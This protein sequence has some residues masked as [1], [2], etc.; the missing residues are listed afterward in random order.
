[1][2]GKRFRFLPCQYLESDLLIGITPEDY[3]P[4]M[5]ELSLKELIRIRKELD[6]FICRHPEFT[7][8]SPPKQLIAT[9]SENRM[10]PLF[11]RAML[12]ASNAT[13]TGPMSA[14]AG[15]FASHIARFL[16]SAFAVNELVVENG[17]DLFTSCKYPLVTALHAGKL[18]LSDKLGLEIP[19]EP[20]GVSTSSGTLGHSF[21]AGQADALTVV[22]REAALA[23]AWATSLA[24]R[25]RK[26]SDLKTVLE[27]SREIPEILACAVIHDG[28]IAVAGELK[29]VLL[30]GGIS[31]DAEDAQS[32]A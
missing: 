9:Y 15:A 20:F 24:N 23:D 3:L 2:N 12:R 21:S 32:P 27:Q 8:M 1:M 5:E 6:G 16:L 11:I 30:E 13:N 14:V 26:A 4:G 10:I 18:S 28:R 29:L 19:P 22:C 7:E 25:V 17:G 31:T